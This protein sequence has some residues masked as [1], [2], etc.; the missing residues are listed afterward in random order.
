MGP[1]GYEGTF[2][3]CCEIVMRLIRNH[4]SVFLSIIRPF[5]FDPLL[6]WE[7]HVQL[8]AKSAQEGELFIIASIPH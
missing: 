7:Y 5:V 6:E 3:C 8:H 1:L 4:S 2:R